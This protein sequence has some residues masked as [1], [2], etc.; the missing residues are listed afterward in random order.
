VVR[1]T[2]KL[3]PFPWLFA[4]RSTARRLI[5]HIESTNR[6]LDSQRKE[7]DR[8]R[9]LSEVREVREVRLQMAAERARHAADDAAA[10]YRAAGA[11]TISWEAAH[12][13]YEEALEQANE[14]HR[15]A[16]KFEHD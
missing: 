7:I 2:K 1:G 15:A 4:T 11:A 9:Q 16:V 10:V 6:I 13:A 8:L 5:E 14:A 12:A 3:L